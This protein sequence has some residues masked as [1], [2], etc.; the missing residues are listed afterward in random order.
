MTNI[1]SSSSRFFINITIGGVDAA[2]WGFFDIE[3]AVIGGSTVTFLHNNQSGAGGMAMSYSGLMN[4]STI[5]Y[6]WVDSPNTTS[7]IRYAPSA[8]S[9]SGAVTMNDSYAISS[10]TVMEIA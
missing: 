3:R 10:I 2:D 5:N 4:D 8:K 6:S 9:S 1:A 7:N